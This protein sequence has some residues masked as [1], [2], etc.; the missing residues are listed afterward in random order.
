MTKECN[1][2]H[3]LKSLRRQVVDKSRPIVFAALICLSLFI[4]T[5]TSRAQ[6]APHTPPS[7]TPERQA[8]FDAMRALGD[9]HNRVFVVRYLMV[10]NGWAWTT[11]DPQS[12]DGKSRYE[13][14]SALLRNNGSGWKV[15]DQP[16][17]EADC[18]DIK[19][20]A[21]IR[22]RYPQAPAGSF[23]K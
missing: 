18:D 22:V 10:Q 8:I 17:T 7:G 4:P 3:V 21:R 6:Q 23:P 9:I 15:V 13:R 11:G 1:E 19:E 5:A 16:C 12:S 14:E 2:M 20:I